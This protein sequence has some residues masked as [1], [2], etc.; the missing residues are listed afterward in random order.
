MLRVGIVGY[1]YWGPNL[2]RNFSETA[3]SGVAAICDTRPD[4][5]QAARRRYPGAKLVAD[6]S[7]LISDPEVDA[8]AIA[9]PVLSHFDLARTAIAAGKHVFIEKPFTATVRQ[10]E[11]LI[12]QAASRN[13][14]LMVDH[15]FLYT[16]AVRR[17]RELINAGELGSLNYYDSVRVNLGLFQSDVNVIWDLAVHDL[18]IMDYLLGVQPCAVSATGLSHVPGRSENI[19][20]VTF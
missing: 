12:E 5:L 2:A 4:R 1:G 13:L 20:Y 14:V 9:T 7:E 10:A 16:G 6:A 3:G 19:A 17:I 8:V 15:T 11:H 18:A